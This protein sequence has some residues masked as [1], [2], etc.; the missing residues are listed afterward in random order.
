MTNTPPTSSPDSPVCSKC[1]DKKYLPVDEHTVRACICTY[2][3]ALKNHLGIELATAVTPP[4][5]SP[6]LK[7]NEDKVGFEVD[8]TSKNLFIRGHWDEVR[9]H[10]KWALG[11]KGVSF[12]FRLT[13]D[14]RLK[15]IYLGQ[16]AYASRS[17]KSRDEKETYNNLSDFVGPDY[18]LVILRLG[19]LGYKNQAMPGILK[20]ALMLRESLKLPTWVVEDI[21]T[22]F[23]QTYSYSLEVESYLMSKYQVITLGTKRQDALPVGFSV[24]QNDYEESPR[25]LP[26]PR[27]VWDVSDDLVPQVRR[28][29]KRK[30]GVKSGG[31]SGVGGLFLHETCFAFSH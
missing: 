30:Q 14:E 2:V 23:N 6:L 20:E 26:P 17:R 1:Q 24:S 8:L 18:K 21:T 7:P 25:P 31:G 22:P 16:E 9:G 3:T 4:N 19:F 11:C 13:T 29:A 28:P 5:G 10:L 12:N 15:A 27:P